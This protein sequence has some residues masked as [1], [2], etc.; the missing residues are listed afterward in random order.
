M[1][2]VLI[3]GNLVDVPAEALFADDG[4]TPF[5][6]PAAPATPVA[7]PA[8]T[9]E[10]LQQVAERAAAA[11]NS[12]LEGVTSRLDEL[13]NTVGSLT[14]AEQREQARLQEE[15][16][17][18]EEERRRQEE[19]GLS[20]SELVQRARQDW[21][22]QLASREAEW[23]QRWEKSEQDRQA[24]EALAA[25]EREFSALRDYIADQVEANKDKI[26][27]QLLSFVGGNTQQEVDASI[28]R[29][30]EATDGIANEMTEAFG[31]QQVQQGIPVPAQQQV[32]APQPVGVSPLAG[33]P[34]FDPTGAGQQTL[35]P[36]Q[37]A[38]MPMDQYAN[39]RRNLGI[40]GQ[41]NNRGLFG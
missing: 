25:K 23:N 6:A 17:R 12:Q 29:A 27:P 35:T 18:L 31:Q 3:D 13:G 36:E 1:P 39:L 38:N 30:I 8:L 21:E 15:Q 22:Q 19:E 7:Q 10:V 5:G 9:E 40:G 4:T 41:Q 28:A 34:G 33:P 2:K 24:A 11:V 26:A 37:I 16:Q 20:A 14:A 32:Q